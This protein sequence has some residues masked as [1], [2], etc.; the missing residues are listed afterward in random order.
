M[1]PRIRTTSDQLI[2]SLIFLLAIVGLLQGCASATGGGGGATPP[3]SEVAISGLN[4]T[5][6]Q[7]GTMVT[8]TGANFG[9]SQGAST[10]QFNGTAGTPTN[11]SATSIVVP[12]PAGATTGSVVVTVGGTA[13]NPVTFTVTPSTPSIATLSPTSGAVGTVVTITGAS[14][15]ATQGTSA[16]SFNGTAG[17]PTSWSS[18]SIVVPAPT[19]ATTGNVVVTVGG[20]ASNRVPFT[21]TTLAP[22]IT[23][24]SP[25]SGVVGTPVTITGTNFGVTQGTST[26]MF[27]GTV[28]V[29][30][31]WSATSI[32]V[33][34]PSGATNG[35]VG[36]TV[37]GV[38][39]N[40]VSF[41]VSTAPK[42][43]SLSTPSGTVGTSVTIIGTNFGATQGTSSVTFNGTTGTPTS[44]SATSIAVPVPPGA[45]TGNVV[46]TAG[47]MASNGM[48]FTVNSPTAPSITSLSPTSGPVGTSVT[49]AGTNFGATQGASTVKF[50]GTTGVPTS[51]NATN[52]VVPVPPGATTGNVFVTV[53]GVA[54]NGMNFTVPPP[55][56]TISSLNPTS[57]P[58]TT[59]VTLTGTNFGATPGT[60]TVT[61]N[62]TPGTPSGW[63]A[64]SIVVPVPSGATTGNVVVTVAG[65]AS[66]GVTFT[67]TTPAPSI[68]TLNPSSAVAGTPVT[69][70]GTNFGASPG[71]STV[72]F[73]GTAGSP[74]NWSA[75]SI[76]VPV[77][78][79]AT[80]G[81]VVVTVGGAPSNGVNFTVAISSPSIT[82][83]NPNSGIVGTSVTITGTN[84]GATQGT[85][86]IKFN[87]TTATPTGWSATSIVVPVPTGATTGN[88]VVSVGGIASNGVNFTVTVPAPNITTL[89]PTSGIVGTSVTIAGSNFGATQGT[90]TVKF[91]GTTGVP[92]SWNATSIVVPVPGGA[93]TGN[94]VV[95][96][97]G[98][99]SNGVNF[100]VS[101]P[102]P[103][104]TTLNPTTGSA[105]TSVTITGTNF[106]ATQ[107]TSTVTFN[108]TTGTPTSWTATSIVVPVPSGAATGNVVVTVG[109]VASNGVSFTVSSLAPTIA[110]INPTSGL[111][112]TSITITGT[113][114][115]AAQGASTVKFNGTAA[116]PTSWSA[117]S[118]VV[119]VPGGTTT[120]NVVV[121]VG[122][123]AS[124]GVT[125]TVTT[126]SFTVSISPKRAGLAVTQT[127]PVTATT[128]DPAGVNWSASGGSFPAGTTSLTL[129]SVPYTAPAGAG[130]YTITATSVTNN[131]ISASTNVYVT[132]LGSV[133]TYHNNVS[134]DGVN[135]QEH[136]L[137]TSNVNT[138]TF[139]KLFSCPVDGAVYAQPLWVAN[140]TVG[141]N[142]HNV[143]V[144]ATAHD[145]IY[146]FDADGP[147]CATLWHTS[148]LG[149]GE[150][151]VPSGT[152]GNL[153]GG[154]SGD[155]TPETG[156]IGTPVIDISTNT[157]YVISKS[158]V[159]SG[160]TFFQR[161]HA[162]DLATGTEKSSMSSPS[163]ISFSGFNSRTELQ[164]AGLALGSNGVVYICW[165]SHE[166]TQPY[167]GLVAGYSASNVSSLVATFNTTPNG[168]EG[169][170]W[171]SGGAPSIDA[172]GNL[173]VIT[174]NGTFD[175]S[176]D[177]SESFLK[178]SPTGNPMT[179]LSSFTA[180]DQDILTNGD[181]NHGGDKDVGAGGAAI[182][183]DMPGAPHPQLIVGGGKGIT[184]GGLLYVLDRNNLGG[185]NGPGG[186]DNVVQEFSFNHAIF[187]TGAFWQNTL[188]IAGVSGPLQAFA[189]NPTTSQFSTNPVASSSFPTSFGF[190]GATA[191]ISTNGTTPNTTLIWALNSS[192][193]CTNQSKGACG[194]AILYAYDPSL[195]ELWDSTMASGDAA[196]NAVKFTLPTI[197]NG[198]VYVGS[199][200]NNIGGA[201]GSTS[202]SGQLDVYGLKPN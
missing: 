37:G 55:P 158:V 150:V 82:T 72:T 201:F 85:S 56:P 60:S 161:L 101:T 143:V 102:A 26:V 182:L 43:T 80:T 75:T 66:N 198:K 99:A 189:L 68:T 132:D 190:P 38:P 89:S 112:G 96:V 84:F 93:T 70:T 42:I 65:A 126:G 2:F 184:F 105:G 178:L 27:N 138:S 4:P 196:G 142:K 33:P 141:P 6:G 146:A 67:V 17:V 111:V 106:G 149:S 134:R 12:V 62:G 186:P 78:V 154:G 191:S 16:V 35:N 170:I 29:P 121:T 195:H 187:A 173:Y 151:P 172:S 124:N 192:Q 69:I 123:V 137:T 129:I 148:L 120:G 40:G 24:L 175:S 177:Y 135:Q 63:N 119:P 153:V 97:G 169:G 8:I 77:P 54:S 1:R 117:T 100:T 171:M 34:V 7:A 156:V 50:N 28:A 103:S 159:T 197:A 91:N 92:T 79:G 110:L 46:V 41:T 179:V 200:G 13:S 188:F 25:N 115:G 39:S 98:V 23:T 3:P 11:W 64:T 145:S 163:T 125:F 109:G 44:W 59:S 180:F 20:V 57:G 88:V 160:P 136:A 81:N 90:S 10:V 152:T 107:G 15:G 167:H 174:G 140:V 162:L 58:V 118:I 47:G 52:I 74:T 48:S 130:T 51:W 147:S 165:A 144:V 114:F 18:T 19:G 202:V 32:A 71:T 73:N 86:T 83:L 53:G 133:S 185:Y 155:I 45:T 14:F 193:Y 122:G 128:N 31:S 113:N 9:T 199:R 87:G 94:V 164:R 21:V 30:T 168:V 116:T 139:G 95:T 181:M 157:V 104:I 131:T 183:V 176:G 36:V 5:T 108:G 166:D 61:F 49:I 194:P 22:S 76:V 127:I